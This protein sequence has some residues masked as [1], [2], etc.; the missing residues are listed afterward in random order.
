L[1][2]SVIIVN[3]NTPELTARCVRS[4]F[5]HTKD[6]SFEVIL[7]DN[8]STIGDLS[9][10][11]A[12]FPAL[13]FIRNERNEGFARGNNKGIAVAKGKFILLL[14]SDTELTENSIA[15]C[16]HQFEQT[17]R[18]GIVTCK[19]LFPDGMVQHQCQ[20]FPSIGLTL[21]ELF[22]LHKLLSKKKRAQVM[23]GTFF[24]HQSNAWPDSVWGA[25]FL[26]PVAILSAFPDKKLPEDFFMYSEDVMWCYLLRR[27][28]HPVFYY[29]GTS[30]IHHL[31]AS[32]SPAVLRQ[33]HMNEYLYI[34]SYRGSFYARTL[35][36][37][38]TFLYLTSRS[39]Y[40]G[41]IRK[42]SFQL[43]LK[44]AKR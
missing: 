21:L 19:L 8:A 18:P 27:S 30:I 7:V 3:Y 29:A 43:F 4:V 1:D 2:V 15:S 5:A 35:M 16:L 6:I 42:L 41:E 44:G 36:L 17:P 39:A 25:F 14:N 34:S 23:L 22:R 38:R 32:A 40:A 13:T 12:E 33:K 28:G 10:L 37:A 20:R 9:G 31:G 11:T 24:D 26:F